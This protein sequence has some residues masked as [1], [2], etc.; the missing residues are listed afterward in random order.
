MEINYEPISTVQQGKGGIN[1]EP[2]ELLACWRSQY[3]GFTWPDIMTGRPAIVTAQ[4]EAT[5]APSA[6][7]FT[8]NQQVLTTEPTPGSISPSEWIPAEVNE[9]TG[10]YLENETVIIPVALSPVMVEA[11]WG[12]VLHAAEPRRDNLRVTL[13]SAR[14]V[15]TYEDGTPDPA[16]PQEYQYTLH[17]VFKPGDSVVL[18][19]VDDDSEVAYMKVTI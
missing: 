5:L 2:L 3:I 11:G 10:M 17:R 14:L 16:E 1:P 4:L 18:R 6:E 7:A 9:F 12:V 15:V 8:V 19:V 13:D